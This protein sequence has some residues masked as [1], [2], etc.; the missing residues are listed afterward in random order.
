MLDILVAEIHINARL[1]EN[2]IAGSPNINPTVQIKLT[3]TRK[4]FYLI[5]ND[6]P[7][8]RWFSVTWCR[9]HFCWMSVMYSD[10]EQITSLDMITT[11]KYTHLLLLEIRYYIVQI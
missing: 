8:T 5:T 10:L 3:D 7:S 9:W 2:T 1:I 6:G 11:S 4:I